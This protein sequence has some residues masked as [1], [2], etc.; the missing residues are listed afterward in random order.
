MLY[1][2]IS[3][4]LWIIFGFAV[5]Y[6]KTK[7]DIIANAE[8][9]IVKAEETYANVKKG[10]AAKMAFCVDN[11]MKVIPEPFKIIFTREMVAQIV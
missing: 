8:N 3:T 9:L 4:V 2:I 7:T 1:N 10:G 6:L 11:I 5:T